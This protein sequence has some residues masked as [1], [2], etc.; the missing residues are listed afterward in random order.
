MDYMTLDEII[1]GMNLNR[2][3]SNIRASKKELRRR[4]Y[5]ANYDT[6]R[7]VWCLC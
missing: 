7:D 6:Y 5:T 4:G 3:A 2:R 1:T